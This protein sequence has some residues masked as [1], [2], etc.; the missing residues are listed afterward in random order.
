MACRG[1]GW[2]R[3]SRD[4]A[5]VQ[6]WGH[7]FQEALDP[8]DSMVLHIITLPWKLI[9]ATVAPTSYCG[10]WLCFFQALIYI[11]IV[12]AFIGD[13]AALMGCCLGLKDVVTAI[14]FVAL[15]TSL[16]DAFASKA[17]L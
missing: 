14:T 11:G 2:Q 4:S 13:L 15:G 8:G 1:R 12:T 16:P 9:F 6:G 17:A 7:Q 3:R 10:G 5:K